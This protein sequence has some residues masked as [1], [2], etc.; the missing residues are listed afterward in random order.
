MYNKEWYEANRDRINE[1]RRIQYAEDISQYCHSNTC[2]CWYKCPISGHTGIASNGGGIKEKLAKFG[3][4]C[5]PRRSSVIPTRPCV[6]Y[7][8]NNAN[9]SFPPTLSSLHGCHAT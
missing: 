6:R 1:K 4:D 2:S 8:W 9:R 3:G 7:R 5:T